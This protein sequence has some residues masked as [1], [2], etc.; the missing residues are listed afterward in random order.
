MP[1]IAKA[2]GASAT[3]K[4]TTRIPANVLFTCLFLSLAPS[5]PWSRALEVRFSSVPIYGIAGDFLIKR[6][7]EFR[8]ILLTLHVQ[9]LDISRCRQKRWW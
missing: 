9:V 5:L 1:P 7:N 8:V 2:L 4:T 6:C 3:R